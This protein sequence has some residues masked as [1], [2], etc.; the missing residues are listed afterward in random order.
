MKHPP[1]IPELYIH[2]VSRNIYD[3]EWRKSKTAFLYMEIMKPEKVRL[4]LI[5]VD[6]AFSVKTG[7]ALKFQRKVIHSAVCRWFCEEYYKT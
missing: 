3:A 4:L 6:S 7:C 2:I 1:R 5:L